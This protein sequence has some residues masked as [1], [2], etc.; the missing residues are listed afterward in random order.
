MIRPASHGTLSMRSSSRPVNVPTVPA[1]ANNNP[2]YLATQSMGIN[3]IALADAD[4]TG[5]HY[6]YNKNFQS[7]FT[8]KYEVPFVQGLSIQGH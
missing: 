6:Y 7:T 3:P 4:M 8:L 2:D 1:Y 5:Y